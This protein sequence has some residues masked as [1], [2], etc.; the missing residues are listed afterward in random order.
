MTK[1]LSLNDL[2]Q[3]YIRLKN[4]LGRIPKRA[5][6]GFKNEQ[7]QRLNLTWRQFVS[8]MGDEPRG[9][10]YTEEELKS[11]I[12]EFAKEHGRPP[13]SDEM[14]R[15]NSKVFQNKFGTWNNALEICGFGVKHPIYIADDLHKCYSRMELY[16]DNF[17]FH[18]GIKHEKDKKYPF[19]EEFNK[20]SRKT[21]D[22]VLSDGRYV[23]LF[24][25]M[26][27]K[28]YAKNVELK[29]RLCEKHNIIL[30]SLFPEDLKHLQEKLMTQ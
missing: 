30:I 5:E 12:L 7:E 22:W 18:N 19:D 10:K 20:N 21:C 11:I 2:K 3:R 14:K 4:E 9:S 6:F 15:P 26:R 13:S 27:K 17:L 28:K 29:Q 8:S 24:G 16:V 25:L 1:K 23:E